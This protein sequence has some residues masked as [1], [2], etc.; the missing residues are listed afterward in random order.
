M[1]KA[2]VFDFRTAMGIVTLS[3]DCGVD[4]VEVRSVSGPKRLIRIEGIP[5]PEMIK[6][7]ISAATQV[8]L[9]DALVTKADDP[10]PNIR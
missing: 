10:V 9:V 2:R 1:D 6:P 3:I 8:A 4:W 5:R 7:T